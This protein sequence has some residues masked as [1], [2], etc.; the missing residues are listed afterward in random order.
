MDKLVIKACLNGLRDRSVA[1]NVPY[2]PR[3]VADEAIRCADAGAAM[4]HF[5]ARTDDGGIS[6]DAAWYAETDRLIR[7]ESDLILNHTTVRTEDVALARVLAT[8]TDTPDPVDAIALNPGYLVLHLARQQSSRETLV[9]PNS[10]ADLVAIVDVCKRRRIF[11]EPTALDTGFLSAIVMLVEDGILTQ[12]SYV[13]LEFGARFGDGFQ[14][15]P[16]NRR[17]YRYLRDCLSEVFPRALALAHGIEQ[18]VFD[19]AEIAVADG[20]HVRVGYEDRATLA[21]G[22][23]AQSNADFVQWAVARGRAEGREPA[24]PAEARTLLID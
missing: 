15:M 17:S 19:I 23:V 14:V 9:I 18:S 13:L 11:V 12:P 24:T 10:Y 22:A 3:E 7:A 8:I 16:G 5:H 1:A 2:T 6:Y 20:S 4:V 21:D